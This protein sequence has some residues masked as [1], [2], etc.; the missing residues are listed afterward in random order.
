MDYSVLTQE[1]Q[2]Y[3]DLNGESLDQIQREPLEIIHLNKFIQVHGKHLEGDH[4]MLSENE[5]VQS[6][7]YIFLVF[8]IS[9][10]Q[11]LDKLCF[12]QTLLVKPLLVFKNLERH[13]LFF[14][15]IITFQDD[16]K[17]AFAKLFD[18]LISEG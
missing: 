5:L 17:A 9:I 10:I 2:R 13:V 11:V 14:F 15:M 16:A 8:R 1:I 3:E 18:D 6:S 7:D 12:N 4:Q